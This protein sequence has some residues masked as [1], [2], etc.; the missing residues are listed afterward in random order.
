MHAKSSLSAVLGIAALLIPAVS[1][2]GPLP[3][4]AGS[5]SGSGSGEYPITTLGPE[6]SDPDTTG[7]SVSHVAFNVRNLTRSLEFYT[8]VFGLRHMYT[9][10]MTKSYSV[11]YMAHSS[12]GKNGTGYQTTEELIRHQHNSQGLVE[13]LYF[14]VPDNDIPSSSDTPTTLM[15]IGINVPDIEAT[16]ARLEKLGVAIYKKI[17]EPFPTEGPLMNASAIDPSKLD[18]EEYQALQAFLAELNKNVIFAADPDGNVLE[19][20]PFVGAA[21]VPI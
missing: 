20:M 1:A 18:P 13:L 19:I 10:Q 11:T 9:V 12:G 14:D 2:C 5:G 17:G 4:D 16:Q 8:S 7:Y 3:R 6:G 21:V 15:H